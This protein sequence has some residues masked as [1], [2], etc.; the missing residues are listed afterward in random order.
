MTTLVTGG[1]GYLGSALV[2]IL[3]EDGKRV[4]VLA[5]PTSKTQHLEELGVE[6][7]RG[8]ILDPASIQSALQNCDVLYHAAAL[9]D[10]WG[11]DKKELMRTE[12]EGTRNVLEAARQAQV[13]RIIYT[14]T[15][16]AIGERKNAVG[17]ETTEHRGYFLST[18]ER[19]KFAADRIVRTYL[20]QGLPIV[21]VNPAGVYGPG[22]LKPTGR[23]VID[24]LNGRVPALF[25]GVT[26]IV[27][28]NDAARGHLLAATKGRIGE[29]YILCSHTASLTELGREI[30]RLGGVRIPFT[31]P[32][33]LASPYAFAGEWFSHLTKRPPV[34]S[35]ETFRLV[36]HGFRVDGSKAAEQLG[37]EYTPLDEGLRAA[38]Q[39]YWEQ[40]L[41]KRQ[42][43]CIDAAI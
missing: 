35:R 38:M 28:L 27:Y 8:D 24:L 4:R 26:S 31:I 7:A 10:L 15:A 16:V 20:D 5:R 1:T 22:D 23:T 32:A 36:A 9:Y 25:T 34:L 29:R 12:C 18:Y 33:P 3:V 39:W 14:S 2:R 17:T 42:P 19:A 30:G 43:A 6:I 13:Q 40:G 37:L 41:L 21:T 11:L